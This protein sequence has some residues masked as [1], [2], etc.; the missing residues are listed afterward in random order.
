M[1]DAGAEP[2]VDLGAMAEVI[3]SPSRRPS[4]PTAPG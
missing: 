2:T 3:A 4:W 1:G